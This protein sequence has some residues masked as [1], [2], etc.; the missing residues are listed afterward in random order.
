MRR[1]V[2]VLRRLGAGPVAP[3]V[4]IVVA[5]LAACSPEEPTVPLALKSIEL[6]TAVDGEKRVVAPTRTFA[7]GDTVYASI[8]TAGG[9]TGTI[10]VEWLV[11]TEVAATQ[12]QTVDASDPTHVAFH[13]RPPAGWPVGTSRIIFRLGDGDKHAAEFEVQ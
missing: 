4:W 10:T 5:V 1:P 11:H 8:G 7:P 12:E 13:F 6:G 9:G 3:G 2:T